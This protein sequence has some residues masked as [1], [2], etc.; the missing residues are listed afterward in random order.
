MSSRRPVVIGYHLVWTAYGTWL[1]NDPRGSGSRAVLTPGLA[2]LGAVHFGRKRQQPPPREL[3]EFYERAAPRLTYPLIGFDAAQRAA[4]AAAFHEQVEHLP[5]TCWACAVMPDHVHL[6]VR[7]HR[8]RAEEMIARLQQAARLLLQQGG[9]AP[10]DHPVWTRG[11]WR[12]F[13]D[14]PSAGQ[15]RGGYVQRNPVKAGLAPQPWAFVRHYDGW[16][17]RAAPG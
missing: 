5:L 16:P 15:L 1:P 4:I 3:R 10:S 12:V 11:G 2:G 8:L 7:K 17:L 14:S 9:L 6:V 13:L